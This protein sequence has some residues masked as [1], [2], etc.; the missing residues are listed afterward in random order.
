MSQKNF[1]DAEILISH[2]FHMSQN[3]LLL[4]YYNHLKMYM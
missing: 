2:N 4:I 3:G 1:M